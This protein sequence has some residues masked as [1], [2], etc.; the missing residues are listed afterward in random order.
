LL[1]L[2]V[3][4]KDILS[5]ILRKRKFEPMKKEKR[6]KKKEKRK[7]KKE[8][9]GLMGSVSGRKIFFEVIEKTREMGKSDKTGIKE[10]KIVEE[11]KFVAEEK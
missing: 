2:R 11:E 10:D 1:F 8:R 7:K 5:I 3:L 4:Y 9:R 6:E